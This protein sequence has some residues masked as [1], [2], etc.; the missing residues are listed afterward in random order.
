MTLVAVADGLLIR[1]LIKILGSY[2]N[3]NTCNQTSLISL[4]YCLFLF[5]NVSG[6]NFFVHVIAKASMQRN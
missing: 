3:F 6:I 4:A 2:L 5:R 1:S